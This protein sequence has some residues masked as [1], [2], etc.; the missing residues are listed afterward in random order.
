VSVEQAENLGPGRYGSVCGTIRSAIGD[1]SS[2]CVPVTV[3]THARVSFHI[4]GLTANVYTF[5]A[6]AWDAHGRK[7]ATHAEVQPDFGA[8]AGVHRVTVTGQQVAPL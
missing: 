1:Y 8:V 2:T 7:F 3:S 4:T 6:V 5:T